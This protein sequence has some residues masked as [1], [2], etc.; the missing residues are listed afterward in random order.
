MRSAV[1]G[2]QH[3]TGELDPSGGRPG[4]FS[5]GSMDVGSLD[6]GFLDHLGSAPL[7]QELDIRFT[8]G[9][10]PLQPT[11]AATPLRTAQQPAAAAPSWPTGPCA[12][13]APFPQRAQQPSAAPTPWYL[14]ARAGV[15][16]PPP[17]PQPWSECRRFSMLLF[18]S[19]S[20]FVAYRTAHEVPHSTMRSL[21][22]LCEHMS[23]LAGDDAM[24]TSFQ[25]P[26]PAWMRARSAS[27]SGSAA[28]PLSRPLSPEG[29][30]PDGADAAKLSGTPRRPTD[31]LHDSL[32]APGTAPLAASPAAG[33]R[34]SEEGPAPQRPQP[35]GL[36]SAIARDLVAKLA[37]GTAPH[38]PRGRNLKTQK[39]ANRGKPKVR[40]LLTAAFS[41]QVEIGLQPWHAHASACRRIESLLCE[42]ISLRMV[43]VAGS[44][45]D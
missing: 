21:H 3:A 13:K 22:I 41:H 44:G 19:T 31:P 25:L 7:E 38:R 45:Q 40:R 27:G 18:Y 16:S 5:F 12:G 15:A 2:I 34:R 9:A 37:A 24:E 42:C 36:T 14:G 30:S 28:L 4:S 32:P 20:V 1:I 29:S 8:L 35:G 33:R 23:H 26:D 11:P 6:K 10:A 17:V 43:C 39:A